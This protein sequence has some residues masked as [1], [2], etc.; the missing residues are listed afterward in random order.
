MQDL[1]SNC[2]KVVEST[3]VGNANPRNM[4]GVGGTRKIEF[5]VIGETGCT[6]MVKLLKVQPWTFSGWDK[7]TDDMLTRV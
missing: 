7:Y 3:Y 4:S 2:I 1:S 6:E 5:Q